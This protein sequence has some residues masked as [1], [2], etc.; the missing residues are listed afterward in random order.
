[1]GDHSAF[2]FFRQ[3]TSHPDVSIRVTAMNRVIVVMALMGPEK[4]RSE[5]IPYLQTK[6]KESDQV[7][8]TL[9]TRIGDFVKYI[10]GIEYLSICISILENLCS[11]EETFVRNATTNSISK[12]LKELHPTNRSQI[13]AFYEFFKRIS[14]DDNSDLF[15]S[16]ISA[17][18]IVSDIY[19]LVPPNEQTFIKEVFIKL[20]FD[21]IALVRRAA[22]SNILPLA[23]HVDN[24]LLSGELFQLLKKLLSDELPTVRSIATDIFIPYIKILHSKHVLNKVVSEVVP[25]IRNFFDEPSWKIRLSI[26]KNF[27][28]LCDCLEAS[29]ISNDIYSGTI[30][31]LQDMEPEIRVNMIK[32]MTSFLKVLG[33]KAFMNEFVPVTTLLL[34]DPVYDVRKEFAELLVNISTYLSIEEVNIYVIDLI[35]KMIQD[36]EPLVRIKIIKK[37][38]SLLSIYPSLSS[39][40]VDI[41]KL[42][43]SDNNWRLRQAIIQVM[44]DLIK[45]L[46]IEFFLSNFLQNYIALLKDD[47]M[48]VRLSC[49]DVIKDMAIAA[50][51][52]D[53]IYDHIYPTIKELTTC[54]YLIRLTILSAIESLLTIYSQLSDGFRTDLVSLLVTLSSDGVPNIRIKAC[55]VIY[56]ISNNITI[57]SVKNYIK[58]SLLS[59]ENDS[60]KDVKHFANQALKQF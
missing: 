5:M 10:G 41:L 34:T 31:F 44:P 38:F 4:V 33:T 18:H 7:L 51:N 1:M 45:C 23:Q 2:D 50:N 36:E 20:S 48:E 26:S 57:E 59:L 13:D 9:A 58:Q 24:D 54:E 25:L 43:L 49:G 12:L 6:Q 30:H 28:D 11:I 8:L 39:K 32:S 22:A 42:N 15:Y 52:S 27:G 19:R 17:C 16:R 53:F 47:V 55:K 37:L 60:D 3:E 35:I 21:E 29:Y 46:G 56:Q 14:T 40:F